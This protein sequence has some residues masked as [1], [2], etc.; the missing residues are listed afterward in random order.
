MSVK[1]FGIFSVAELKEANTLFKS[2][3]YYFKDTNEVI[4]VYELLI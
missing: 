3:K 4:K 1:I 2:T